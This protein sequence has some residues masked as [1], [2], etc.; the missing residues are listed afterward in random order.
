MLFCAIEHAPQ[1]PFVL[2]IRQDFTKVAGCRQVS[3]LEQILLA[4]G[5]IL[6]R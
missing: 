4:E 6:L 3:K 1:K 5:V 2:M